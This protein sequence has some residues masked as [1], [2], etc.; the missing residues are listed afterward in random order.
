MQDRREVSGRRAERTLSWH[1]LAAGKCLLYVRATRR[2]RPGG[3]KWS[4]ICISR[5]NP[6]MFARFAALTDARF[7]ESQLPPRLL[8]LLFERLVRLRQ[9]NELDAWWSKVASKRT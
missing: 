7:L 9:V 1:Q 2:V 4:Y 3:I 6:K 8:R 5:C